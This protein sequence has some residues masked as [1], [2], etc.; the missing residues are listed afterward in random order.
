VEKAAER[1]TFH[2]GNDN[3]PDMYL[4]NDE[5]DGKKLPH[6]GGDC[7]NEAPGICSEMRKE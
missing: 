3:W 7:H 4:W 2:T 6:R 1:M 5:S